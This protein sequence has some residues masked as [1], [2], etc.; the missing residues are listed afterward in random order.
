M[1]ERKI[2]NVYMDYAGATPV[3]PRVREAMEPYFGT[4]FANPSA[5]YRAGRIA[6]DAIDQII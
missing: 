3:D 1:L 6:K 2:R 4:E 5:L